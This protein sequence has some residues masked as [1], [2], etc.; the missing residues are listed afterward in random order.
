MWGEGEG[1]PDERVC[2]SVA[3]TCVCVAGR[4]RSGAAP[5]R[6]PPGSGARGL[7]RSTVSGQRALALRRYPEAVERRKFNTPPRMTLGRVSPAPQSVDTPTPA[8]AC[9]PQQTNLRSAEQS[10]IVGPSRVLLHEACLTPRRRARLLHFRRDP[11][12]SHRP[13]PNLRPRRLPRLRPRQPTFFTRRPPPGFPPS[14]PSTTPSHSAPGARRPASRARPSTTSS[15]RRRCFRILTIPKTA[16]R[17][18]SRSGPSTPRWREPAC[19]NCSTPRRSCAISACATCG[20]RPRD[21][22]PSRSRSR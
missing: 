21:S 19:A 9:T 7:A 15:G 1:G 10:P 13:H 11:G 5:V 18:P 6:L 12:P 22:P 16:P 2:G 4:G 14:P 20:A 17:A 8:C 3:E